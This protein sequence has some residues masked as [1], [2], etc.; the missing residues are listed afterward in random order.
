MAINIYEPGSLG[1]FRSTRG[2]ASQGALRER[3]GIASEAAA[4]RVSAEEDAA[5][6]AVSAPEEAAAGAKAASERELSSAVSLLDVAAAATSG[7]AAV[8]GDVSALTQARE[9]E[10]DPTKQAELDSEIESL[11]KEVDELADAAEVNGQK[12]F[13]ETSSYS[14]EGQTVTLSLPDISLAALGIETPD[15]LDNGGGGDSVQVDGNGDGDTGFGANNGNGSQSA[16]SAEEF[17]E[18]LSGAQASLRDVG[19]AIDNQASRLGEV[20]ETSGRAAKAQAV[21]EGED[22][23]GLGASPEETASKVSSAIDETL[24]AASADKLDALRVQELIR[25]PEAS[26]IPERRELQR[27]DDSAAPSLLERRSEEERSDENNSLLERLL[28]GEEEAL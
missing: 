14:V 22:V 16:P 8:L 7:I 9:S 18:Q 20:V 13:G 24:V 21:A 19:A 23:F 27:A 26:D 12:I 3:L 5:S 1:T 11:L 4:S 10:V 28:A 17:L 25:A 6:V 2:T 15:F